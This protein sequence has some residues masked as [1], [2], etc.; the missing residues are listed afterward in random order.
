MVWTRPV[1]SMRSYSSFIAA[2]GTPCEELLLASRRPSRRW[3]R[4][5]DRQLEARGPAGRLFG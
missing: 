3:M 5:M 4:S 2:E 1:L